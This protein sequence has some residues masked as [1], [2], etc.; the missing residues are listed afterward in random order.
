MM[1]ADGH[2]VLQFLSIARAKAG[3]SPFGSVMVTG[4]RKSPIQEGRVRADFVAAVAHA[5]VVQPRRS[6]VAGVF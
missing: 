1:P 2:V 4:S 6:G 5:P 3:V